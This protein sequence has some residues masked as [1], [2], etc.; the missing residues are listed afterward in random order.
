MSSRAVDHRLDEPRQ[1]IP[2]HGCVPAEPASVSSGEVIVPR[3]RTAQTSRA[4][5]AADKVAV[6]GEPLPTYDR[7]PPESPL[8]VPPD[9]LRRHIADRAV[10]SH[11]VVAIHVALNQA[12]RIFHRQRRERPNAFCFKGFVSSFL[13]SVDANLNC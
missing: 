4:L 6:A 3:S 8:V 9:I 7:A 11:R 1:I 13:F 5:P 12:A 2:Q 10:Q